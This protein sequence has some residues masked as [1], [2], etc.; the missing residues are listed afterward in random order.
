MH[1]VGFSVHRIKD[2]LPLT[3]LFVEILTADRQQL[4]IGAK[5]RIVIGYGQLDNPLR[6][7]GG[8]LEI[9]A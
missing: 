8:Q 4:L 5:P 3:A 6:L 9:V 1:L 7:T 2:F